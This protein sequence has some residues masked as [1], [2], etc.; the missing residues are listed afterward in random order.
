MSARSAFSEKTRHFA[1]FNTKAPFTL[2]YIGNRCGL[3][4]ISTCV[5]LRCAA[6]CV[7]LRGEPQ[8]VT[9]SFSEY[10]HTPCN[11]THRAAQR[12]AWWKRRFINTGIALNIL[13]Y[14][15]AVCNLPR[16]LY[17]II[18][19][20][21]VQLHGSFPSLPF[22]SLLTVFSQSCRSFAPFCLSLITFQ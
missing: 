6:R 10:C 22:L 17:S 15:D 21:R 4:I 7:A 9:A 14:P 20:M 1:V 11:E 16:A 2:A 19:F 13:R 5:A 8:R 3:S 12:S 18:F